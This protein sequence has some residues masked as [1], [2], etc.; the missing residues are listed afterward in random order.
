MTLTY[1][2]FLKQYRDYKNYTNR[3]L[4][5]LSWTLLL[6]SGWGLSKILCKRTQ[7]PSDCSSNSTYLETMDD[8][9]N[10]LMYGFIQGFFIN[11]IDKNYF[12]YLFHRKRWWFFLLFFISGP[13]FA[14]IGNNKKMGSS[15]DSSSSLTSFQI[16]VY[17]IL[18]IVI[19]SL[20]S[21][22]IYHK[23]KRY[24]KNY[25]L[26]YIVS[27]FSIIF[28]FLIYFIIISVKKDNF[29]FHHYFLAWVLSLFADGQ[30]IVSIGL[31]AISSGIFVQGIGS[32]GA[33]PLFTE[34]YNYQYKLIKT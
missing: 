12:S 18:G 7:F 22:I 26:T 23:Y 30:D 32:Y 14:L 3:Y 34:K 8:I 24:P 21:F 6:L 19:F 5:I 16:T 4:Q 29:H 27:R 10:L 25:F 28:F 20:L 2:S 1:S 17:V 31:L 33:D 11:I 13:I 15:L 9:Q